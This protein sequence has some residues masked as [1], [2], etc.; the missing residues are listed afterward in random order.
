MAGRR[1]R[2]AGQ[3][4]GAVVIAAILM[5]LGL[6]TWQAMRPMLAVGPLAAAQV[7]FMLGALDPWLTRADPAVTAWL[8]GT[9]GAAALLGGATWGGWLVAG[10]ITA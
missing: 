4:G 3:A 2:Q 9:A 10:V 5:L 7:V 8:K 6:W 1:W